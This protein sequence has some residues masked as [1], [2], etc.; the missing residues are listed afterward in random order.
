MLEG[1]NILVA[2]DNKINQRVILKTLE[3]WGA[4]VGI[5]EN[6]RVA[7][8]MLTVKPYDIVLMDMQMP[9][10][11]G[12][13]ATKVIRQT[14]VKQP[15]IIALTANVMTEDKEIC[16]TAGMND[17]IS[18]PVKLEDLMNKLKKWYEIII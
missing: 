6:G 7:I 13:E 18:K 5:A 14:V 10:I 4:K 16:F 1:I 2:E 12:L 11:D 15:V 3:K 17:Y 9:D 8:E